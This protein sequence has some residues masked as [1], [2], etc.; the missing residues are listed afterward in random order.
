MLSNMI[1]KL[2]CFVVD[3]VRGSIVL[4]YVAATSTCIDI[5][6]DTVDMV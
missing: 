5:V 2:V 3:C 4:I 6:F 1:Q